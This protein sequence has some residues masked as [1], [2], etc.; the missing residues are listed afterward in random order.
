MINFKLTYKYTNR[1]KGGK[2]MKELYKLEVK[3]GNNRLLK[4]YMICHVMFD[5]ETGNFRGFANKMSQVS[6]DSK[7]YVSG[8]F[9]QKMNRLTLLEVSKEKLKKPNLYIFKNTEEVGDVRSYSGEYGFMY[10]K[11]TGKSS[12]RIEKILEGTEEVE[13]EISEFL[14]M[15]DSQKETDAKRVGSIDLNEIE[16]DIRYY[17]YFL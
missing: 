13:K 10:P 17:N 16:S 11:P 8:Y 6:F 7:I 3:K 2:G 5:I 4:E 9:E 15:I 14:A 12:I 1:Q